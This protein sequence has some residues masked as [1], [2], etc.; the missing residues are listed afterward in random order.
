MAKFAIE[1]PTCNEYVQ[2]NTG[3]FSH[4][5]WALFSGEEGLQITCA[6]GHKVSVKSA[7]LAS[8]QCPHCGNQVVHD[9]SKGDKAHCP[10][11]KQPLGTSVDKAKA[12]KFRCPQC[13]CT[14]TADGLKDP[15]S[16]PVCGIGIDV[17]KA[18]QLEKISKEGL[19]SVI[20]YEGDNDTFVW[21]HPVEDF[22]IGSQLIVHESQ[23]AIFFRDGQAL[24]TFVSGRYTL[25]TQSIPLINNLYNSQLEPSGM[26]H[27][28]VY[29]INMTT[30]MAIKWGTDSKVRLFDPATN[31]P[32]EIGARGEFNIRV[33]D[34]RR[35]LLRLVGTEGG[36]NRS[37]LLVSGYDMTPSA[38]PQTNVYGVAVNPVIPYA[39]QPA[40]SKT[41]GYFRSFI[42]T[43]VKSHLA[44][45]IKESQI[46]ILEIDEHLDELSINLQNRINEGLAEY[47]LVLSEFFVEQIQTPDDDPN[48]KLL[49]QQHAEMYL[50][51]R[52]EAVRQAEAMARREREVIETQTEAQLKV[53]AAQGEG[54]AAAVEAQGTAEAYRLMAQ[55]EAAEM[56]MKGYT[57]QQETA[58]QVGL[59]AMQ[60]GIAGG[61]GDGSGGGGIGGGL[62]DVVGLG[63]ALGAMGG[64]IGLTK[65][66]LSPIMGTSQ[67]LGQ[68]FGAVVNPGTAQAG[69][70]LP[71]PAASGLP[72]DQAFGAGASQKPASSPAASSWDCTCGSTGIT[73]NFCPNCGAKKPVAAGT[74]DCPGCGAKGISANFCPDCGQKRPEP[75]SAW[76]CDCG[77]RGNTGNFCDD[78][79]TKRPEPAL[80]TPGSEEAH[81]ED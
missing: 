72:G 80:E 51:P 78:C 61:G 43:R 31:I 27:S 9:Q 79:G 25:E 76:D 3:L 81:N 4:K 28:E 77:K 19:A 69:G 12:E 21:K 2:V 44:R 10:V 18:I 35:L 38:E 20:K 75:P 33:A 29:F 74:W 56:Q 60:G 49:K 14:L 39:E 73:S 71:N 11:C 47:G 16:C 40:T 68:G 64:V 23:E 24:D 53:I 48:Y 41:S 32:I 67:E 17:Q 36:L 55:A 30:Q 5:E 52:Q 45:T 1:C 66:A 70:G 57:Y 22:N 63:V 8:T 50:K 59:E 46:N 42:M 34:S 65:D 54:Q 37:I 26:F 7:K 13:S 58:R 62:G 6:H 15:Y